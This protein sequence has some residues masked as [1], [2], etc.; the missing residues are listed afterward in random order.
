MERLTIFIGISIQNIVKPMSYWN[1]D[2]TMHVS[3]NSKV[4]LNNIH[5]KQ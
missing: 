2:E 1:G 4:T 5:I 3:Q